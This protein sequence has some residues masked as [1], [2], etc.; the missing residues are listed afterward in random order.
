LF[1]F[2]KR[3]KNGE[4][5]ARLEALR[6]SLIQNYIVPVQ[7]SCHSDWWFGWKSSYL[8]AINEAIEQLGG[9]APKKKRSYTTEALA[10]WSTI[11]TCIN[12]VIVVIYIWILVKRG[13]L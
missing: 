6:E 4:A 7:G 1:R 2:N 9:K 8:K 13:A 5:I 3:K 12:I 10:R 11:I